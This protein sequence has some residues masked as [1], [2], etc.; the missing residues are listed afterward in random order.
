MRIFLLDDGPQ[1][2]AV[3]HVDHMMAV[4]NLHGW[5]VGVA[6]HRDDFHA[7]T[8]KLDDQLFAEFT[9]TTKQHAGST[10]R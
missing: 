9:R 5:R 1:C 7:Q 8:L 6:V 3:E 10:G 4:R 2:C